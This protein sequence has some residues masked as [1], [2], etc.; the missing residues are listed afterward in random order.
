MSNPLNDPAHWGQRAQEARQIAD[1]LD[2]PIAKQEMLEI[3]EHYEQ[4]A[5]ITEQRR[6]T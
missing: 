2:D 1:Q 4:L 5:A 3:A 6:I